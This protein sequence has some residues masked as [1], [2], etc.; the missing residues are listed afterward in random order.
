[1]EKIWFSE[2]SFT[3]KALVIKALFAA[4][5]CVSAYIGIPLQPVLIL[6]F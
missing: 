6:H 4:V 3:S 1:M 2:K 5:L